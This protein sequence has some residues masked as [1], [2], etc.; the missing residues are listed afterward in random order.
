VTKNGFI[1]G[2]LVLILLKP[3]HLTP[4]NRNFT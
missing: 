4:V 2:F 1:F 3:T